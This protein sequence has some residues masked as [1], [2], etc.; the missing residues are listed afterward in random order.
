M[1]HRAYASTLVLLAVLVAGAWAVP[2]KNPRDVLDTPAL[3][4][5]LAARAL[6]NGLANA[7]ERVVAVGQRG[8][9]LTSDDQGKS[10]QQADVPVGSDLVAVTFATKTH[11]WAVGHDGVVLASSDSILLMRCD[12]AWTP[13]SAMPAGSMVLIDVSLP[14]TPNAA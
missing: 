5:A 1:P 7:G 11:G 12:S 6:I 14:P 4:S 8:H 9:V 13:T 2:E 10:W 3:K